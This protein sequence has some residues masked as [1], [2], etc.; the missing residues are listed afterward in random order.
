MIKL[1][2]TTPTKLAR[3]SISG[4]PTTKPLPK[5]RTTLTHKELPKEEK[6]R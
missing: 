3:P 4:T 2:K 1:E 5:K 6:P